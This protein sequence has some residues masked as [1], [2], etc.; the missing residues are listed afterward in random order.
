MGNPLAA[1]RW[2]AQVLARAGR[3]I[4]AGDVVLSGA[5]GPMVAA[6]PGDAFEVHIEGVGAVRTRFGTEG[7]R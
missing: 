3:P 5:L 6:A 2:L 4:A 1:V 7:T